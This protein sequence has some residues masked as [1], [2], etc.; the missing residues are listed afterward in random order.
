MSRISFEV[1]RRPLRCS[2]SSK[3]CRRWQSDVWVRNR[4]TITVL[5]A[6]GDPD[7]VEEC[8]LFQHCVGR[9]SVARLLPDDDLSCSQSGASRSKRLLVFSDMDSKLDIAQR[10][11]LLE[12]IVIPAGEMVT[13]SNVQ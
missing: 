8:T 13:L 3:F 6:F 12:N 10:G 9:Y 11:V 5:V 7:E 1:T 2:F 4:S